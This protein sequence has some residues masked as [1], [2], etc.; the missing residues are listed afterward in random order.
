MTN[1]A[2]E[3][4]AAGNPK[5]ILIFVWPLGVLLALLAIGLMIEDYDTS[6]LGYLALPTLKVNNTWVPFVVGALPQISQVVLFYIFGRDT[7]KGWALGIAAVFFAVDVVTD[8]WYK[9][10][11]RWG[12]VPLALAE[13]IFIFT[14]G[15]EVL[16]AISIGFI[17]ETFSDFLVAL[18]TFIA[19]I[20]EAFGVAMN[21]LGLG[22]SRKQ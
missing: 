14:L 9:S 7:R 22:G 10:D 12:L 3:K 4:I 18:S 21:A 15:S 20:I 5:V 13:S 11:Q 2:F 16:F 6:R 8:T 1:N 17:T 19:S